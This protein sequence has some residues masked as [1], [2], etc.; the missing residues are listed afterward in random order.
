MKLWQKIMVN[1]GARVARKVGKSMPLVGTAVV[2]GLMGYEIKK[3]GL[4]KGV[5]NTALDATPVLGTAK[6]VIELFT[7]DWL[8]DKDKVREE[9]R[10]G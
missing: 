9:K 7:G 1:G 4:V 10:E 8:A 5:V 6:N 3:K 2:I